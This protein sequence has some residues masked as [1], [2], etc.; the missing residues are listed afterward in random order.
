MIMRLQTTE[1]KGEGKLIALA[2]MV[3]IT[4]FEPARLPIGF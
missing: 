4:G 2:F 3:Q 1:Y